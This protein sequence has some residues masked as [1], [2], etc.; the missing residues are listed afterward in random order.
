MFAKNLKE[1]G[2]IDVMEVDL[3][4]KANSTPVTCNPYKTSQVDRNHIAEIMN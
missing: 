4:E 1:L 2:C 3:I